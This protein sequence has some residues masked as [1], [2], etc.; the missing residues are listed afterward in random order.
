[1]AGLEARLPSRLLKLGPD[2]QLSAQGWFAAGNILG[3][4]HGAQWCYFDGRRTAKF[5]T[6]YLEASSKA[7][8]IK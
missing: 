1:M 7:G 8:M 2:R 4:F 5:V 3:G 6:R